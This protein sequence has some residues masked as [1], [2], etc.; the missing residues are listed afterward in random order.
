MVEHGIT[1]STKEASIG[2]AITIGGESSD[3]AEHGMF[4]SAKEESD[5]AHLMEHTLEA[6]TL[7]NGVQT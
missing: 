4:P 5:D 1:P 3:E 2:D 6:M 7:S